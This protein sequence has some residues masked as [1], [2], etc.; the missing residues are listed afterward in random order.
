M[1]SVLFL[2]HIYKNTINWLSHLS[3]QFLPNQLLKLQICLYPVELESCQDGNVHRGI[4]IYHAG[5]P[6][7]EGDTTRPCDT[8]HHPSSCTS[9]EIQS[10][11]GWTISW[12][13]SFLLHSV[14][15]WAFFST[16]WSYKNKL[17]FTFSNNKPEFFFFIVLYMIE[18]LLNVFEVLNGFNICMWNQKHKIR[19]YMHKALTLVLLEPYIIWL[20]KSLKLY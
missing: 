16:F 6:Q 7:D 3:P 18:K 13:H 12:E 9:P 19:T 8:G 1:S 14:L 4:V 11:E 17:Y 15:S 5:P 20:Q 10:H 2:K